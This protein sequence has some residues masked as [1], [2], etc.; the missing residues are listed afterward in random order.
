[1]SAGKSRHELRQSEARL[2]LS[3]KGNASADQALA[4]VMAQL[5]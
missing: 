1:M 2:T 4:D 5:K 3:E